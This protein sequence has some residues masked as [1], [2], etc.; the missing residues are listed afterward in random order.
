M[1]FSSR[2]SI[3]LGT[4]I[5]FTRA[6]NKGA[7]SIT[8]PLKLP[9]EKG[10][11]KLRSAFRFVS[12]HLASDKKGA[13]R[14]GHRN[15]D[16]EAMIENLHLG[17]SQF[18]QKTMKQYYDSC[19][20]TGGVSEWRGGN[21]GF[22]DEDNH[23]NTDVLSV[24]GEAS[25][26]D[27][28]AL[29][30][31]P[32]LL[33]LLDKLLVKPKST[34]LK[35]Q[36]VDLRNE[37][38]N[39]PRRIARSFAEISKGKLKYEDSVYGRA[40]SLRSQDVD[41]RMSSKIQLAMRVV[42]SRLLPERVHMA[43]KTRF[44]SMNETML[45]HKPIEKDPMVVDSRVSRLLKGEFEHAAVDPNGEDSAHG[46]LK[47][48]HRLSRLSS[49][50]ARSFSGK[51]AALNTED[52]V[53][54]IIDNVVS[55]VLAREPDRTKNYKQQAALNSE[56]VDPEQKKLL[57]AELS[58]SISQ[59][60]LSLAIIN[61]AAV[62]SIASEENSNAS[63]NTAVRSFPCDTSSFKL[64]KSRSFSNVLDNLPTHSSFSREETDR[65]LGRNPSNGADIPDRQTDEYREKR[66]GSNGASTVDTHDSN[67]QKP[68]RRSKSSRELKTKST[69]FHAKESKS[70]NTSRKQPGRLVDELSCSSYVFIIGD[71]NY[72]VRMPPEQ[73]IHLVSKAEENPKDGTDASK[74][75]C[76]S[77]TSGQLDK[78]WQRILTFDELRRVLEQYPLFLGY[79]EPQIAFPPTYKRRKDPDV[80]LRRKNGDYAD[81]S[82]LQRGYVTDFISSQAAHRK[83]V[84]GASEATAEETDSG[85]DDDAS[86]VHAKPVSRIGKSFGTWES[87][88]ESDLSDSTF[89]SRGG[90]QKINTTR[91]PS[92]PDRIIFR[93]PL[94]QQP[95]LVSSQ[96][97]DP[98]KNLGRASSVLLQTS[99]TPLEK[100]RTEGA[101]RGAISLPRT[102]NSEVHALPVLRCRSYDVN[103]EV[104]GSDH[105]PVFAS[106]ELH[107]D[108][109]TSCPDAEAMEQ[110]CYC[111]GGIVADQL[112][113]SIL[114]TAY[115]LIPEK[116]RR[117]HDLR[118]LLMKTG[119]S[120][121]YEEQQLDLEHTKTNSVQPKERGQISPTEMV[122]QQTLDTVSENENVAF[123]DTETDS[124]NEDDNPSNSEEHDDTTT[125]HQTGQHGNE[126]D[127]S[128]T[129]AIQGCIEA[130]DM[131]FDS[132]STQRSN[133]PEN[134]T[135]LASPAIESFRER[136]TPRSSLMA[137][138]ELAEEEGLL[139]Q[140]DPN[141]LLQAVLAK[142]WSYNKSQ[143]TDPGEDVLD[144]AYHGYFALDEY[145]P[146][147]SKISELHKEDQPAFSAALDSREKAVQERFSRRPPRGRR[148]SV[149]R[150]RASLTGEMTE[151]NMADESFSSPLSLS[152]FEQ[153]PAVQQFSS[154]SSPDDSFKLES[155][156]ITANNSSPQYLSEA[157]DSATSTTVTP[158]IPTATSHVRQLIGE[159]R[160][161]E[162]AQRHGSP[163]I[164]KSLQSRVIMSPSQQQQ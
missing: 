68:Y 70:A 10:K 13:N 155:G 106:F 75:P 37:S 86:P 130:L 28:L 80:W 35:T 162:A 105:I 73:A 103:D 32:K 104:T 159:W 82:K 66:S 83:N 36:S 51:Q 107:L 127:G 33:K 112:V 102:K 148:R 142:V 9:D 41:S 94:Q 74:P 21:K 63:T 1:F 19:Y 48:M 88:E 138:D 121:L 89:S 18:M 141:I 164:Y 151:A 16:A 91:T 152:T 98:W 5:L 38:A 153:S 67:K 160:T 29:T 97:A 92:Y 4:R 99:A 78:Y 54:D 126:E 42:I 20:N 52:E 111:T 56:S 125:E 157:V 137:E 45:M 34:T 12:C 17:F 58:S 46:A 147:T 71:L 25:E 43:K 26:S 76:S 61:G 115:D 158:L 11:L 57:V 14:F 133:L 117:H 108:E 60:A 119:L 143:Y 8:L 123:S 93:R 139:L 15:M 110:N 50:F 24:A 90:K 65:K 81:T 124:P 132:S 146:P 120:H 40:L 113:E 87:Y 116:Y 109:L 144:R 30:R 55:D 53:L 27:L 154:T 101:R 161:R 49:R 135:A 84:R 140:S 131:L 100:P 69:N 2:N 7:V 85:S 156:L 145:D 79:E 163:L 47:T 64:R 44:Q 150:R 72:R 62:K 23:T 114:N 122:S 129:S 95:L 77:E 149:Q 59:G 22:S 118:N 3:S 128:E 6:T 39:G 136:Q 31:S 134:F 96:V